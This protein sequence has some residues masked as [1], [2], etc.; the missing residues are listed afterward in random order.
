MYYKGSQLQPAAF[1]STDLPQ[2]GRNLAVGHT[3]VL[4][5]SLVN[6]FRFGYNYAYHLNAPISPDGRNWTADLGLQNLSA[7]TFPLAY[8]R[9]NVAMAGFPGRAK[10]A[11]RRARQRI[12][13]AC[14]TRRARRSA[15]TRSGLACRRSSA[16][17]STSR[18]T[19]RAATSRSTASSPA[20]PSR[21]T[22]SA[23]VRRAPE[24]SARRERHTTRRR[25]RRSSTT[26]GR[27]PTS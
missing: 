3:W 22:C 15:A 13:T 6:E 7:A 11:T 17:S 4:S 2:R 23:T 9:P 24:R 26:T 14:R 18:T 20:T 12:S 21:I 5:P 27:R 8:G 1:T 10:A 16:S 19:R 25:S